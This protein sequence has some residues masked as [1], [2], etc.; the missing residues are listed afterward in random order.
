MLDQKIS[1]WNIKGLPHQIATIKV[2]ENLTWWEKLSLRFHDFLHFFANINYCIVFYQIFKIKPNYGQNM[3]DVSILS[4]NKFIF[5]IRHPVYAV[6]YVYNACIW[7][8]SKVVWVFKI[9]RCHIPVLHHALILFQ[10]F[11]FSLAYS[12]L[13]NLDL[14]LCNLFHFLV[15][16]II[17]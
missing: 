4:K 12:F 15:I 8:L 3:R 10:F 13:C 2:L 14:F 6:I 16:L 7:Q 1:V 17:L 11:S 9:M 5:M